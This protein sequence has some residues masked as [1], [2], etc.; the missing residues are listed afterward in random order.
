MNEREVEKKLA[1]AA[2]KI[3]LR[4]FD[5]VWSEIKDKVDVRPVKKKRKI[6]KWVSAGNVKK[7]V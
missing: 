1:E 3:E 4:N 5:E 7:S 6:I 2:D